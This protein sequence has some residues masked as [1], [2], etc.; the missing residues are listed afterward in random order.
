MTNL[1][2]QECAAL[3]NE[4]EIQDRFTFPGTSVGG[5]NCNDGLTIS[6]ISGAIGWAIT[7]P[8]DYI[9]QNETI[10]HFFELPSD[11]TGHTASYI[12]GWFLAFIVF[13]VLSFAVSE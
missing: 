3:L 1:T 13:L 10:N 5:P 11:V 8:G 2:W 4:Y 6:D 12:L 7:W 9:L